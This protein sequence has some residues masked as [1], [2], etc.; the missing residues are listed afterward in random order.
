MN[1]FRPNKITHYTP[2]TRGTK[3]VVT[4]PSPTE[5]CTQTHVSL[6]VT[7]IQAVETPGGGRSVTRNSTRPRLKRLA[8]SRGPL[9]SP[10]GKTYLQ[11]PRRSLGETHTCDLTR[12]QT[13]ARRATREKKKRHPRTQRGRQKRPAS[14]ALIPTFRPHP[15]FSP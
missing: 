2:F 8:G 13:C 6:K 10:Q 5:L 14:G 12:T 1:F 9:R 4:H 11:S 15:T 3:K 7:G